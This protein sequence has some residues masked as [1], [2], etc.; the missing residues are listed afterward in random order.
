MSYNVGVANPMFGKRHSD[1]SV[2]KMSLVKIGKEKTEVHKQK[3]SKALIGRGLSET[4]K[5]NISKAL[6]GRVL[7]K[8][9]RRKIGEANSRNRKG[10]NHPFWLGGKS[11]EPYSFE[12]NDELKRRIRERDGFKCQMSWCGVSE[13]GRA[14]DVHHID[15]DKL[16]CAEENLITLCHSCNSKVNSNRKTWEKIFKGIMEFRGDGIPL[17]EGGLL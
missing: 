2:L 8:E 10:A 13:N 3:I 12:F 9:H 17:Y 4:Q 6:Q 14:H 7:S 1:S 5:Q 11:F 15:Y 16:N